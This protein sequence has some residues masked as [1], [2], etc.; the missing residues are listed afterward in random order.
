MR[1]VSASTRSGTNSFRPS[2]PG[3]SSCWSRGSMSVSTA[4]TSISART[5]S[6]APS[7][8]WQRSARR[9]RLRHEQVCI[10]QA[11]RGRP[12]PSAVSAV[13]RG[14]ISAA[15]DRV[16]IATKAASIDNVGSSMPRDP[17]ADLVETLLDRGKSLLNERLEFVVSEEVRPVVLDA[18]ADQLSDIE[19]IDATVDAVA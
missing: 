4:T 5:A 11:G 18:F 13:H 8:N 14:Q 2:K 10:P 7:G 12:V 3:S 6:L 9:K 17:P 1:R 16:S 15:H 19:R